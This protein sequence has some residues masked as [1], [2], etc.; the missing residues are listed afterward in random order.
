RDIDDLTSYYRRV[1]RLDL[2]LGK[3]DSYRG[4]LGGAIGPAIDP[5]HAIALIELTARKFSLLAEL[6]KRERAATMLAAEL[7]SAESQFAAQP[8]DIPVIRRLAVLLRVNSQ[9]ASAETSTAARDRYLQFLH[10]QVSAHPDNAALIGMWVDGQRMMLQ[11]LIETQQ[12]KPAEET[13]A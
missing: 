8:A 5:E 9:L 13:L 11:Y 12:I 6:G 3:V 2:A 1:G 10:E 4:W 7:A